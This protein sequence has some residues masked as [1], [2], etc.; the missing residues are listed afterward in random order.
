LPLQHAFSVVFFVSVGMLFDPSVL[1]REPLAVLSVLA[2]ILVGKSIAAFLIVQLLGYPVSTAL[3]IS[4]SLAQIGEFSFILATLG[5]SLGMMPAEGRD[6][7][8]AGA[9]LS[10]T[11]NPLAFAVVTPLLNWIRR[12]RS[13]LVRFEGAQDLRL[14]RLQSLL[15][16][17]RTGGPAS[18]LGDELISRWWVFAGL[19][20]D[21][22]AELLSL[23]TPRS[24]R[25]GDRI[26]RKGDPADEVFF[27]SS[28]T[29]E[30]G[31]RG[32]KIRLGPGDFFGEMA[33]LTGEPRSADVTAIDYT[34][35]FTLTKAGFEPFVARHPELRTRID[36]VAVQRAEENV[37]TPRPAGSR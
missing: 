13:L 7:I 34:Q 18:V 29:V 19:D 10:L 28:G 11:L 31:V 1:I 20:H 14:A 30:V 24:A 4:A 37:S 2:V 32:R 25:P 8:L 6:L 15:D 22:R 5:I 9:I 17:N 3:T 27:I 16:A 23:F 35:L 12:W 33:L 26:I 21:K 36:L